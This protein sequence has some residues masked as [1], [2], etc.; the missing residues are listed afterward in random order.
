MRALHPDFDPLRSIR[1]NLLVGA[2]A[3]IALFGGIGGWAATTD[4]AGAVLAP[5]EV[6]VES[7]LKQVQHPKGGVVGELL[8]R[9]GQRVRAG[10]IVVRLDATVTR[11]DLAVAPTSS[12]SLPPGRHA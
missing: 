4:F 11:A 6:V 3:A 10:E 1:L 9:D 8:V 7:N 5:G 2:T 12:T